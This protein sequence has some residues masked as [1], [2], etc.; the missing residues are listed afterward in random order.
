MLFEPGTH[1]ADVQVGYYQTLH[2][3]GRTPDDTVFTTGIAAW[4]GCSDTHNGALCNFWR[5][6]ENVKV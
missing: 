2:G 5:S 3:L 4:D 1:T 6:A